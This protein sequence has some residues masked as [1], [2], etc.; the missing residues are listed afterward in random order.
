MQAMLWT[1][2]GASAAMAMLAALADR[3]RSRRR[4]LDRV[5]WVPWPLLVVVG[6]MLALAFA[7]FAIRG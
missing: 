1:L 6:V 2:A 7:A 3:R 4:D 5:G